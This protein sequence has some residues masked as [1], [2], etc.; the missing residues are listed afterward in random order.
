MSKVKKKDTRVMSINC[1]FM[2]V[3]VI[4]VIFFVNFGHFSQFFSNFIVNFEQVNMQCNLSSPDYCRSHLQTSILSGISRGFQ[5]PVYRFGHKLK[6]NWCK[7]AIN[8]TF[9]ANV[10]TCWQIFDVSNTLKNV[11]LKILCISVSA[12]LAC[13]NTSRHHLY[14]LFCA[15]SISKLTTGYGTD[16]TIDLSLIKLLAKLQIYKLLENVSKE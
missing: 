12:T 1:M 11:E 14:K 4:L 3:D 6:E 16:L 5:T 15:T 7:T 2:S 9:Q 10:S 13:L 8:H